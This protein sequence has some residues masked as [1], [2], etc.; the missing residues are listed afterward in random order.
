MEILSSLHLVSV[1]CCVRLAFSKFFWIANVSW[2]LGILLNV[3]FLKL[4]GAVGRRPVFLYSCSGE[5]GCGPLESSL[6]I[7]DSPMVLILQTVLSQ[8]FVQSPCMVG[9]HISSCQS[10]MR[11]SLT[12]RLPGDL[13]TWSA[14]AREGLMGLNAKDLYKDRT[15]TW[16]ISQMAPILYIV[17]VST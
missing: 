15:G 2:T 3:V 16:L 7:S 11:Q 5:A 12:Y 13:K 1:I 6:D 10:K 9:K 4:T 8:L 17:P 14:M